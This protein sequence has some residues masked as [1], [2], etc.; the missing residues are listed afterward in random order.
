VVLELRAG[1]FRRAYDHYLISGEICGRMGNKA[2]E[3]FSLSNAAWSEVFLG[4][5]AAARKSIAYLEQLL[6]EVPE[7][8][9]PRRIYGTSLA[10]F[11]HAMGNLTKTTQ[12]RDELLQRSLEAGE[13]IHTCIDSRYLGLAL[14]EVGRLDEAA[15]VIQRGVEA[16]DGIGEERVMTRAV[17]TQVLARGGDIE[18]A[19]RA[20]EETKQIH[21][22]HNHLRSG[23]RLQMAY[24]DVVTAERRWDEMPAAFERAA[25]ALERAGARVWRAGLLRDWAE[26]HIRRGE[27]EDPARALNLLR[28]A[29]SE[30][31]A[32]GSTGY[33]EQTQSRIRELEV[34]AP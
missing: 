27:P 32:M 26:A 7:S 18:R 13:A 30:Y 11:E 16:A 9:A 1:D 23:L 6:E 33:V 2:G 17:L 24:A 28:E 19:R 10:M 22:E 14:I 4:E 8:E 29:L 5:L 12:M 15:T 21:S 31:E 25:Q 34:K 3:L 20:Y